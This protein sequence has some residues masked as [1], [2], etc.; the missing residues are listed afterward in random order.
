MSS[1]YAPVAT[2]EQQRIDAD[3]AARAAAETAPLDEDSDGEDDTVPLAPP[4][5][6]T[7]P[8]SR[9][10][11]T[12]NVV[13][14][15]LALALVAAVSAQLGLLQPQQQ[16]Q[17]PPIIECGSLGGLRLSVPPSLSSASGVT[18]SH[19]E[20]CTYSYISSMQRTSWPQ[21]NCTDP[22]VT[23]RAFNMFP[24][25]FSAIFQNAAL[26][27][28]EAA[29]VEPPLHR[30]PPSCWTAACAPSRTRCGLR[31][32]DVGLLLPAPDALQRVQPGQPPRYRLR[33]ERPV[34]GGPP[35]SGAAAERAAA[36][37]R[38]QRPAA[39]P[40]VRPQH[41]PQAW[42]QR[43]RG[44]LV[45]AV[46]LR[47]CRGSSSAPGSPCGA[48]CSSGCSSRTLRSAPSSTRPRPSS[49][50]PATAALSGCTCG[51]ATRESTTTRCIRSRPTWR[52]RGS[53]ARCTASARCTSP[54][55]TQRR[56]RADLEAYSKEGWTVM[57]LN[58]SSEVHVPGGQEAAS[59]AGHHPEIARAM[60]IDRDTAGVAAG[61]LQ[62]AGGPVHV[63]GHAHGS[64]LLLRPPP[65]A[66]CCRGPG[67]PPLCGLRHAF[68]SLW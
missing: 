50:G 27:L 61:R 18:L 16:Q 60:G 55:T 32:T 41:Q 29:V 9:C 51:T 64:G 63:A 45:H 54:Q 14:A 5:S 3:A 31:R 38:V 28:M 49:A 62:S 59:Y 42:R 39:A 46:G 30:W 33:A 17:L 34:E 11:H 58:E 6:I 23:W 2:T 1:T 43:Q 65:P 67:L 25:G 24:A 40:S 35:G 53:C 66:R 68:S 7:S 4:A 15:A 52:R 8:V 13:L 22:A 36:A 57:M 10:C 47:R 26:R 37:Q 12:R 20:L 44:E 21:P 19:D 56:V 48:P